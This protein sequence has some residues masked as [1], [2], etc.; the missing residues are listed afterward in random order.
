MYKDSDMDRINQNNTN[1]TNF[2]GIKP[3]RAN[4]GIN[5]GAEKL[6]VSIKEALSKIKEKASDKRYLPDYGSFSPISEEFKRPSDEF[7]ASDFMIKIFQPPVGV[8]GR[9]KKRALELSVYKDSAPYKAT[10]LLVSG[11]NEDI[12]KKLNEGELQKEI[13]GAFR[14]LSDSLEKSLRDL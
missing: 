3:G 10:R 5:D 11:S 8:E 1:N 13:E 4:M 12:I 9:D 2:S 7:Y 14:S 6:E